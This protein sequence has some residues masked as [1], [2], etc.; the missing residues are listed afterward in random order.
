MG[1][2]WAAQMGGAQYQVKYFLEALT[3]RS[4]VKIYYLARKTPQD[5]QQDGYQIVRVSS[6][7]KGTWRFLIGSWPLYRALRQLRP[8]V[9]YQRGLTAYTGVCAFYCLRHTARLVF[10]IASDGDVRRAHFATWHPL[11]P[12]RRLERWIAEYGMRRA[13]VIVA[14]TNDQDGMLRRNYGLEATAVI[15][16]FHPI[17][18]D[19]NSRHEGACMRI[20]WIANFK[21]IKN[22]EIFVN[23]AEAFAGRDDVKF[24][25]IG[26]PGGAKYAQ[27]HERMKQLENLQYLGE[28]P[29]ERVNEELARGDILVNT[30]SAEGF[31]N[32]FIQ[33]WLH[34]TPVVSCFVDPDACLSQGHA[35]MVAGSPERLISVIRELLHNRTRIRELGESARAYGCANHH[36]DRAQRLVELVLNVTR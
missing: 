13:N 1:S 24:I 20:L 32:T 27:L 26:R 4:D 25:M 21:A 30:S 10:H 15:P 6:K 28:L 29:V 9:I 18:A 7:W 36:P 34:S 35:G 23:L 16:N 14:Q 12:L 5:L 31:P 33:A 11:T 8:T 19:S 2:H 17:P 22:P 3:K